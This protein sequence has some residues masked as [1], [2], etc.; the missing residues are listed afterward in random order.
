MTLK[1]AIAQI[2]TTR[3]YAVS[4][5]MRVTV[6]VRD[7]KTAYGMLKAYVVPVAGSGGQWIDLAGLSQV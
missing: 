3:E 5:T 7:I 4:P 2:G 1:D 6:K